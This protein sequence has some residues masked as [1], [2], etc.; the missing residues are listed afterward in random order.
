MNREKRNRARLREKISLKLRLLRTNPACF[1][2]G[3]EDDISLPMLSKMRT[4][5]KRTED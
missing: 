5:V 3:M 4:R 1:V 2:E